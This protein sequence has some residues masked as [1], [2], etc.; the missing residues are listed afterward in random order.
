[1]VWNSFLSTDFYTPAI[2]DDHPELE[3]LRREGYR[4][5]KRAQLL[6]I[7]TEGLKCIAVAG[8][9]GKTTVSTMLTHLLVTAGIPCNAFLGGISKNYRS[10]GI[11]MEGK[12][13]FILEADEFDRSFLNLHPDIAIITSC[14]PDHLDIYGN[15]TELKKAFCLFI[16]QIREGGTLVHR[17]PLGL[18]CQHEMGLEIHTYSM[19]EEADYRAMH[20][21]SERDHTLFDVE[22]PSGI[23]KDIHLGVP[24]RI[25]VENA[26]AAVSLSRKLGLEDSIL[27]EA[28]STFRGVSRRFDVR[29]Q[30]EDMVYI[31][32][33]AHHPGELMACIDSVRNM[34]PGRK[35]TGVFQPHL[36]S[37]TKDFAAGFA[38][39]LQNLDELI[40]LD[41]YPAREE[42]IPGITSGTIF[43]KIRME[44]KV[45]I[46]KEN[47]MDVLQGRKPEVLLTLGAG[48]IDR[49]VEPI[50][51][52]YSQEQSW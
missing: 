6:G 31:D 23:L 49:Y 39:S 26:L 14:D 41:I 4:I 45:L 40:L 29:I 50:V 15:E 37:R 32:D 20:I 17:I 3:F 44:N 2:P 52:L 36:Y 7:L 11:F 51:K 19:Q 13:W 16:S 8:T 1:M 43:D 48:D 34:Y 33:Y 21:R 22:T 42:P 18:D 35:I 5:I 10:N 28:L 47:L 38:S 24:G 46:E 30:R 9:H 12:G 25:N 27:K